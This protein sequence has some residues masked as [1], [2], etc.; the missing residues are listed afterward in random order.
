MA[1][2]QTKGCCRGELS[3]WGR[4][5]QAFP[6]RQGHRPPGTGVASR[7]PVTEVADPEGPGT[8]PRAGPRSDT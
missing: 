8:C 2:L 4:E 3:G 6:G 7:P 1:Q 5:E